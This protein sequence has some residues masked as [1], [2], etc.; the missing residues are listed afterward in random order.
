MRWILHFPCCL[1]SVFLSCLLIMLLY[2]TGSLFHW[3][4]T[5][6]WVCTKHWAKD[7]SP[8]LDFGLFFNAKYDN[9]IFLFDTEKR[10]E[11]KKQTHPKKNTTKLIPTLVGKF[12]LCSYQF[13]I[14]SAIQSNRKDKLFYL[15]YRVLSDVSYWL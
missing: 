13:G 11:K 5:W 14:H 2:S 12:L 15:Q 6:I 3:Y 4:Q 1:G 10:K 7:N 8:V 9:K